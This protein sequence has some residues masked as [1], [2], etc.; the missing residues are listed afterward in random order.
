[1]LP[2]VRFFFSFT[3]IL[4]FS[5]S[6]CFSDE[7]RLSK[8]QQE[9]NFNSVSADDFANRVSQIQHPRLYL[10]ES[11]IN[12][13]VLLLND[14]HQDS[15]INTLWN[16]VHEDAMAYVERKDAVNVSK[17]VTKDSRQFYFPQL[18]AIVYLA[19]EQSS[20]TGNELTKI[21]SAN[22]DKLIDWL[23]IFLL[24]STQQNFIKD[25]EN[26]LRSKIQLYSRLYDWLYDSLDNNLRYQLSKLLLDAV[27]KLNR[28]RYMYNP[29]VTGGH[30]RWGMLALSEA[31]L[32]LHGEVDRGQ[33]AYIEQQL[34]RAAKYFEDY[35]KACALMYRGGGSQMGWAY[36]SS[37]VELLAFPLWSGILDR[38][39]ES[40]WLY[41]RYQWYLY[42]LSG[43]GSYFEVG[44]AWNNRI[45]LAAFSTILA[46]GLN[47]DPVA[48]WFLLN[49][50]NNQK[51]NK[52][53][54]M[55]PTSNS[56][57]KYWIY[58][59][60]LLF[61]DNLSDI[62]APKDLPL[63]KLFSP[64][65]G[66]IIRD[67]WGSDA[68][69]AYF[70][71]NEFYTYNHNHLDEGQLLIDY[72]GVLLSEAGYYDRYSSTHFKNFYTR[73]IAHNV[74]RFRKHQRG[75]PRLTMVARGMVEDGGQKY[76]NEVKTLDKI[77]NN[78]NEKVLLEYI[79]EKEYVYLDIDLSKFY[80]SKN[81]NV[82]NRRLL[83]LPDTN[84]K[85]SYFILNDRFELKEKSDIET[86][87]YFN[88]QY[89]LEK[90]LDMKINNDRE[91]LSSKNL[92]MYL[93]SIN[94]KVASI[95][96]GD[97]LYY[98]E[99]KNFP[100]TPN[101]RRKVFNR[102]DSYVR[103]D[104]SSGESITG[105]N[106][107]L[108]FSVSKNGKHNV[109]RYE[110]TIGS[111]FLLEDQLVLCSDERGYLPELDF[112]WETT[113]TIDV[114]VIGGLA[115]EKFILSNGKNKIQIKNGDS[116]KAFSINA[117]S[118]QNL[119]LSRTDD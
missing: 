102:K 51:Y 98:V 57:G 19:Y 58:L 94:Q 113:S 38:E 22:K 20:A 43:Q 23:K 68:M 35:E 78:I 52:N 97:A 53:D 73:S 95:F 112:L 12:R 101:A 56:K 7:D 31:M 90:Q 8:K 100:P 111:A 79:N 27:K 88:S 16:V 76:Q 89:G 75:M 5:I 61:L 6:S 107:C 2:L 1:M 42:G 34:I 65:G 116:P 80:D 91:Y 24:S 15:V 93:G 118:G 55:L 28:F 92:K 66:L 87:Y 30:D 14:E 39:V 71:F 86:S 29:S 17:N 3:L 106:D 50:I 13:L 33:S 36:G 45:R 44:N 46:A 83:Y 96:P 41:Q 32:S 21:Q 70:G 26:K 77:K 103:V 104:V 69:V 37:S 81:L 109:L 10:N 74:P 49:R 64:S 18:A 110:T 108:L 62:Q 117:K 4:S 59:Y 60:A 99:S 48:K 47:E 25:D 119:R 114:F 40:D 11:V 67:G 9:N 105:N 115:D 54:M 82:L 72:K 85:S 84:S 63:V